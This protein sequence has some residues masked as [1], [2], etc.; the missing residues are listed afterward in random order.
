MKLSILRTIGVATALCLTCGCQYLKNKGDETTTQLPP[1][2][3]ADPKAKDPLEAFGMTYTVNLSGPLPLSGSFSER[4][5]SRLFKNC[6][7]YVMRKN[8]G[9]LDIEGKTGG[10]LVQF[11]VEVAIKGA[12]TF[13]PEPDDIVNLVF[14]SDTSRYQFGRQAKYG[15]T[16]VTVKPDGSGTLTF[17]HWEND[18]QE[19]E[20]G[21]VNWICT[22]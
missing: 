2:P 16:S 3:P 10:H 19:T 8:E 17:S 9:H 11:G 12:G 22:K 5:S 7:D 14:D 21:T 6:L 20:S 15:S 4:V 18:S 1:A 13:A